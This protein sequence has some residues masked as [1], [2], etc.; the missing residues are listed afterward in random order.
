[1]PRPSSTSSVTS[2]YMWTEGDTCVVLPSS[3]SIGTATSRCVVIPDGVG[4]SL[5][6]DPVWCSDEDTRPKDVVEG[7]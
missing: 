3:I 7:G 6:T 4:H 5:T 1:V 2:L